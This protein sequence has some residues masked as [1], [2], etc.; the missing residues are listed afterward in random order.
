[1]H[2]WYHG[3]KSFGQRFIFVIMYIG[4]LSYWIIKVGLYKTFALLVISSYRKQTITSYTYAC[5]YFYPFFPPGKPSFLI[6]LLIKTVLQVPKDW[7]IDVAYKEAGFKMIIALS[8]S[9]L[10]LLVC[11]IVLFDSHICFLLV[12]MI[13]SRIE[14]ILFYHKFQRKENHT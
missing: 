9:F 13:V 1:M 6:I 7:L 2:K 12:Y 5:F 11:H 14:F 4:I 8:I 3:T 10:E